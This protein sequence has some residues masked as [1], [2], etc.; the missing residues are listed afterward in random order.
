MSRKTKGMN[1]LSSF[2]E[3]LK[4]LMLFNNY[5]PNTLAL[6]LGFKPSTVT[7]LIKGER[8][9][10]VNTLALIADC[11]NC[12]TDFLLGFETEPREG[13]YKKR[14]PLGQRIKKLVESSGYNGYTFCRF[15]K[16]NESRYYDWVNEKHMPNVDSIVKIATALN[17]SVDFVLGREE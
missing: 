17:R 12:S 13:T 2:V 16:I 7:R 4:E 11:F 10:T 15:A 9:P 1:Y 3:R 5:N 8:A 6:R 14:P